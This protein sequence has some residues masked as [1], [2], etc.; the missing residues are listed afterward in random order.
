MLL[1]RGSLLFGL[2]LLIAV[3]A[4]AQTAPRQIIIPADAHPAVRAA[5][6]IIARKLALTDAAITASTNPTVPAT[7]VR[8]A[9]ATRPRAGRTHATEPRLRQRVPRR[10]RVLLRL[11]LRQHL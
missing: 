6:Q 4:S 1:R 3:R 9:D 7:R 2:A 10:G 5:A 8:R 11:P